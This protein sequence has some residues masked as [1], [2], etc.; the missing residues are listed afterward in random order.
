MNGRELKVYKISS[1][2]PYQKAEEL[3][4]GQADVLCGK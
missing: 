1:V 4:A 2:S 3:V